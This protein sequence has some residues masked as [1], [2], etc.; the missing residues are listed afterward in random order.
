MEPS[1]PKALGPPADAEADAARRLKCS[2]CTSKQGRTY[3]HLSDNP[4]YRDLGNETHLE[5][6]IMFSGE[7]AI[8]EHRKREG[9]RVRPQI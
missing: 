1:S 7:S 8:Q 3:G 6:K 2:R 5:W 9:P 4:V